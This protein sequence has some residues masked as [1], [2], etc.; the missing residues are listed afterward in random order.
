VILKE[1]INY[2]HKKLFI[3]LTPDRRISVI[4]SMRHFVRQAQSRRRQLPGV[5]ERVRRPELVQQL[6][7]GRRCHTHLPHTEAAHDPTGE[8]TM[9][10]H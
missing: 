5:P 8:R 1:L 6:A 4:H 7:R 9:K 2:L 10:R 3:K